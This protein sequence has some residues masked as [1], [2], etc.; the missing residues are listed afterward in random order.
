[1]KLRLQSV[2]RDVEYISPK[3]QTFTISISKNWPNESQIS[4]TLKMDRYRL[5]S[6]Y[7]RLFNKV[8]MFVYGVP[9]IAQ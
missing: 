6:I 4:L 3:T 2:W 7:S 1:M 8:K 9:H 5:R